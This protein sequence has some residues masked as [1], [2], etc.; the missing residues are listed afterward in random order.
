MIN[1]LVKPMNLVL[2][3]YSYLKSSATKAGFG[4][5]NATGYGDRAYEQ[6]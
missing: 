1:G 2:A 5:W 3:G 4:L 6:L